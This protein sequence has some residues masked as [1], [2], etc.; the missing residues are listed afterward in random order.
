MAA[1]VNTQAAVFGIIVGGHPNGG[2]VEP[3]HRK[4]TWTLDDT[5]KITLKDLI[6]E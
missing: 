6:C 3:P 1:E 4:T 5:R 2:G